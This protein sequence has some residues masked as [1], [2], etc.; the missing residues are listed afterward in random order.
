MLP[1][2]V[3]FADILKGVDQIAITTL[4]PGFFYGFTDFNIAVD[5]ISITPGAAAPV[6]EPSVLALLAAGG[7][8]LLGLAR[9]RRAVD[10]A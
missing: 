9:R 2:G 8:I 1:E 7:A 4:V 5:N 10:R 6:P 3:T